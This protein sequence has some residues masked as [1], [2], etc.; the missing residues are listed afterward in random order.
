MEFEI[1]RKGKTR[2]SPIIKLFVDQ[3]GKT[4]Y[5]DKLKDFLKDQEISND[6][7]TKEIDEP[8]DLAYQIVKM[9]DN[10]ASEAWREIEEAAEEEAAAEGPAAEEAAPAEE[11]SGA[12]V[13]AAAAA[14]PAETMLF[15][16][17]YGKAGAAAAAARKE[18]RR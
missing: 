11:E 6:L 9:I 17:S 4:I 12:D 3:G 7:N 13:V 14:G 5:W 2:L 10:K 15:T 16:H 18:K 8:I 1:A